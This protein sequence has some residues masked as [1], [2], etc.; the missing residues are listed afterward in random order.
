MLKPIRGGRKSPQNSKWALWNN[1]LMGIVLDPL[2]KKPAKWLEDDAP[3]PEPVPKAVLSAAFADWRH[4]RI[5]IAFLW[6]VLL[7]LWSLVLCSAPGCVCSSLSNSISKSL[8]RCRKLVDSVTLKILLEGLTLAAYP[9]CLL[10]ANTASLAY[11]VKTHCYLF[12]HQINS[13]L[14]FRCQR[15]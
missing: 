14:A 6:K 3:K 9:L 4:K 12:E 10:E 11:R 15:A 5:N 7:T 8:I 2:R 1:H 13:W